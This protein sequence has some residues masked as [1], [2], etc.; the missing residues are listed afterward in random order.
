MSGH[1]GS[2]VSAARHGRHVTRPSW[3]RL[4]R[5]SGGGVPAGTGQTT[6]NGSCPIWLAGREAGDRASGPGIVFLINTLGAAGAEK[7]VILTARTLAEDGYAA[8]ICTLSKPRD[9]ERLRQWLKDA[10]AAGVQMIR[11]KGPWPWAVGS[12]AQCGRWLRESPGRILW[13]WGNRADVLGALVSGRRV[14]RISALSSASSE[15]VRR[16]APLWRWLDGTCSRYVSNSALNVRQLS[17]VVQGV[18]QRSRVLYN[19][20]E[21]ADLA[22]APVVLPQTRPERLEVVMLGNLRI[23]AKGYDIAVEVARRARAEGVPLHVRIAGGALEGERLRALIASSGTESIVELAGP[24]AKP[25]EF[26]RSGHAFMLLSR[27][28]GLPNAW[29]EA[30]VVGLPCLV[31]TVGDLAQ[32]TVDGVHARH[33]PVG[34][35][36]AAVAALR[37]VYADWPASLRLGLAGR[38]LIHEQFSPEAFRRRLWHC[39]EGLLPGATARATGMA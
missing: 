31:T 6:P 30:M 28:E 15:V 36:E 33:I 2:W 32:L 25:F 14:P 39:L 11:P 3:P 26:L 12:L 13:T 34:N 24:V 22:Q 17:E 8:A 29:L 27:Y 9:S 19:G 21:P 20:L 5:V 16:R 18:E 10:E 38:A 37:T 35:V 7:Q 4:W 1:G 23:H